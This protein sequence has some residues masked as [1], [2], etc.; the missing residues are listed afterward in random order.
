MISANEAKGLSGPCAMD[1]V[2]SLEPLIYAAAQ[3]GKNS[4]HVHF[5][6]WVNEAYSNTTK[7]KEAKKILE[8]LGYTVSFF[9][10]EKSFGVDMY[11]IISW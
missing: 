6:F 5:P 9:Y 2:N 7:F 1:Q 11:T 8:Q 3:T 4:V 10:S